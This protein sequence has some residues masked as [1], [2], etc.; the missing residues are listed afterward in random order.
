M[1]AVLFGSVAETCASAWSLSLHSRTFK[2]PV[3]VSTLFV[4][5]MV[6]VMLFVSTVVSK[7]L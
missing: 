1:C 4:F 6:L 5:E 7:E 2:C 3:L